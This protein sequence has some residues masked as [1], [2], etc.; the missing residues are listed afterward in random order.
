MEAYGVATMRNIPDSHPVYKLLRPAFHYTMAI[1]V[2][3]RKEL[4]NEGGILDRLFSIGFD[5]SDNYP[6]DSG[7]NELTIRTNKK[8]SVHWTNIKRDIHRRGVETIPN[9]YY[10]DDAI[11]MWDTI[12]DYVTSII[13]I[14]YNNDIDVEQDGELKEWS[15]EV[16]NF[17]FPA[18]HENPCGRGFPRR[19]TTKKDLIEYCTLIIFTGSAQHAAVNFGQFQTY[20]FAKC[21]YEH[22]TTT[23]KYK[24]KI[25]D[26]RSDESTT[27]LHISCFRSV[28]CVFTFSVWSGRGK[29]YYLYTV[30]APYNN[31]SGI[32]REIFI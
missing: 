21:S 23:T 27:Y 26:R 16:H 5:H 18:F 31:T 14:F 19:I 3:A 32:E 9:Y 12:E 11:S 15:K 25:Y 1:N 29:F 6:P 28:C 13:E 20:A 24:G 2:Q 7:K 22:E 17:A 10:R 4:I 8:Y 30:D